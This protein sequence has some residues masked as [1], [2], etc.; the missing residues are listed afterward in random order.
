[1]TAALVIVAV[2]VVV[3]AVA[4]WQRRR[5][6]VVRTVTQAPAGDDALA[7]ELAAAGL[8]GRGP[9]V[10]H[11]SADWCGPCAQVR[12]L[13]DQV[14]ADLGGVR[15]LEVDVAAHPALARRFGVLSLPT[16]LVL[17]DDLGTR[18]RVS[19]VPSADDL[20]GALV[21]LTG[22]VRPDQRDAR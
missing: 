18:A 20:R 9:L 7:A 17:G 22:S 8:R 15:H 3:A 11:F 14:C 2:L 19:G 4:V 5:S 1:M 12:P 13:V 6:G 16:V 21:P 10:L